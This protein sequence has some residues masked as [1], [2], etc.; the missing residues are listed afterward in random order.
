MMNPCF[1]PFYG[2]NPLHL[3][4]LKFLNYLFVLFFIINFGNGC[5]Y[6]A[7]S[8]ANGKI[9]F[10]VPV[11]HCACSDQAWLDVEASSGNP[12]VVLDKFVYK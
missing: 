3:Y 4:F 8:T 7:S 11:M 10:I 1:P 9:I 6:S 5:V 12:Q 2:I